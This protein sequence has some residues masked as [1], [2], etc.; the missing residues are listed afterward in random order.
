MKYPI[1]VHRTNRETIIAV[2][3]LIKGFF[4]EA[5]RMDEALNQLKEKFLCFMHDHDIQFEIIPVGRLL[6]M[7]EKKEELYD[8]ERNR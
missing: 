1:L 8:V 2:C 7:S 4:A 5:E 3:P 6:E